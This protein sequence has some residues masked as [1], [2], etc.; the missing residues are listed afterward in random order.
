MT[1]ERGVPVPK[2]VAGT[3]GERVGRTRTDRRR[4]TTPQRLR[5]AARVLFERDGFRNTRLSDISVEA[6]VASG[7]LYNYYRSKHDL[8]HEL[9]KDVSAELTA[10]AADHVSA[11]HDPVRRIAEVNRIYIEAFRRNARV[12]QAVYQVR[13]EDERLS[14]QLDEV[15]DHFQSRVTRSI[16]MWQEAGLVYPDLDPRH[17]A[18]ALTLMVERVVMAWTYEGN[19]YDTETLIDT[20]NKIW[21]RSLGLAGG[22]KP[23]GES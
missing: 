14:A 19:E 11:Q 7:T 18:H 2:P 22:G 16:A 13:D 1:A 10:I 12:L 23:S 6:K 5:E 8:L 3:E 21:V 17:T 20:L 15:A 4:E 9:M